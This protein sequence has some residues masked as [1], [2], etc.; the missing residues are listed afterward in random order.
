MGGRLLAVAGVVFVLLRLWAHEGEIKPAAIEASVWVMVAMLALV[1]GAS[2]LM[3]AMGWRSLLQHLGVPVTAL[4]ALRVYGVSQIAKYVPGNIFHL[5][6]RQ[7]LGAAAGL[8]QWP[9]AK[10]T[11]WE[12]GLIVATGS[13]FGL[14]TLPL[15][16]ENA[17]VSASAALFVMALLVGTVVLKQVFGRAMAAAF[18]WHA[19]FLILSG[20]VFVG[21]VELFTVPVAVESKDWLPLVGAYVLAWLIG[22]VALG[23]PAGVGVR[24]LVLLFLLKSMVSESNLLLIVLIG[25]VMTVAGDI[26]FY[27]LALFLHRQNALEKPLP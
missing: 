27:V 19:F 12:L 21:L 24:E 15:L 4:W 3:L 8:P 5:A 16:I 14:L 17:S 7:A 13:V 6:G 22:L 18:A 25:R 9:L 23:A 26:L 1:Y 11:L 10:S 20:V 2:N